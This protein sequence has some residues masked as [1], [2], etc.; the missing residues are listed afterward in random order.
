MSWFL[1]FRGLNLTMSGCPVSYKCLLRSA[2]SRQQKVVSEMPWSLHGNTT[3]TL[4]I[5]P[6]FRGTVS[7]RRKEGNENN[8]AI[9]EK[10]MILLSSG[11]RRGSDLEL[12]VTRSF[13]LS[14]GARNDP[15][16]LSI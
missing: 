11:D 10:N 7:V 5:C 3:G 14:L 2:V 16:M 8:L 12:Q 6:S 4:G 13:K 9:P 15:A 1:R